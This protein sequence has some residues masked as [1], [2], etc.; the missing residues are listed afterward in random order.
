MIIILYSASGSSARNGAGYFDGI[1]EDLGLNLGP[2]DQQEFRVSEISGN[3][4]S[5]SGSD[6]SEY[7]SPRYLISVAQVP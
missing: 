5:S 3:G 6:G 2:S 7:L 4:K 1:S